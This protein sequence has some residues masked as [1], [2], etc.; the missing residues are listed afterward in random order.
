MS[1]YF[2]KFGIATRTFRRAGQGDVNGLKPASSDKTMITSA[3][4]SLMP[5]RREGVAMRGVAMDARRS[6]AEIVLRLCAVVPRRN[7]LPS[8]ES[9][10]FQNSTASRMAGARKSSPADR[11]HILGMSLHVSPQGPCLGNDCACE[12]EGQAATMLPKPR[13]AVRLFIARS[14]ARGRGAGCLRARLGRLFEMVQ[15]LND[16][17]YWSFPAG[18]PISPCRT[19]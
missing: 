4:A 11:M 14:C 9:S 19:G 8:R 5:F 2:R 6:S 10:V 12:H 18:R 13:T 17:S 1:G 15:R 7:A 16:S 3:F